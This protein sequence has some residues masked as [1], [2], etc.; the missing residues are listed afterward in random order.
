MARIY[1]DNRPLEADPGKNVLHVCLSAGFDLPYFCWHPAMGSVGACRLCAVKQFRD[2]NDTRGRLVVSCMTPAADGTRVSIDDPEAKTFRASVIEWLMTYHPHDCP[3]CDEGG[4][5]HLQDMTLMTGH[6]YR[7]YRFKKRT[8]RNQYLGPFINHEMN[9]CIEC[10]R[11]VRFYRDYAGGRDLNVFASRNRVYFGRYEDGVLENEFSG[12]LI[13][14]CPTGVFTDKTLQRHYTRKWDLQTAPSVCTHCGLGCN[15]TP[16]ERYGTLRRIINRYNGEVNGYFLC[17]RGRF[18]YEFVNGERR[19]R[20]PLLRESGSAK[21]MPVAK[22]IALEHAASLLN[23]GSRVIG[24]GSPRASLEANFALRRL[25]GPERFHLGVSEE[26]ARLLSSMLKIL[27]EGPARTPSVHGVEQCDAVLIL[28]ED[29]TNVAPRLALALRQSVR[30]QPLQIADKLKIARWHDAAVRDAIQ[31]EKGPLFIATPSATKLDEVATR[32]YRG[33]PDDIARLGFAVAHA[34]N[35][36]APEVTDLA[37]EVG[38]LAGQIAQ[39]LLDAHRP[40]VIAGISLEDEAIVRAAANVTWALCRNGRP[41]EL[42]FTAPECNSLGLALM[43]GGSLAAAFKAVREGEADTAIVLENDLYRRADTESVRGFL[44]SCKHVIAIDHLSHRTTDQAEIVLPAGSFAETDGTFVSNEGRAQRFF[45]VFVPAGEV[46][47]SWRWLRDIGSAAGRDEITL[48]QSLDDVIDAMAEALPVFTGVSEAA[49][50]ANFRIAGLKVAR[51][52]HRYS[53]RTAMRAQISVHEPK[54]P[55][56]PD[57][58]LVFSME[59]VQGRVPPSLIPLFWA[60][61]WN[62]IQSTNKFQS[63][64]GGPL[65]GGD[66]GVRLIE[67]A[68]DGGTPYFR[69]VPAAFAPR[70]GSWLLVPIYHIFGSEELSALAP[71]VAERSPSPYL[72]LNADDALALGIGPDDRAEVRLNGVAYRLPVR[73]DPTLPKGVAGLPVGLPGLEGFGPPAWGTVTRGERP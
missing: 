57:T 40:L 22:E 37:D 1:V 23:G 42:C 11:C 65:T 45:Q 67:P 32:T 7:R 39:A 33:A 26:D 15:T 25:V 44:S 70:Q 41:A 46:Q 49:P 69:D 54:P 60:P 14:V 62:S 5:C 30:Q 19:L 24:I 12:N 68:Q 18:G 59:G 20:Q 47:E 55:E 58:P 61:G 50:P 71:G 9:R 48:W 63:E 43:G 52:S 2:E 34:L 73:V 8:F 16:G 56:D 28:G 17:D 31:H 35:A 29:V 51:E 10:Y 21:A 4:E 64:V 72:A 53:G 3:V 36:E 13:E 38:A 6:A 66:P 27:R